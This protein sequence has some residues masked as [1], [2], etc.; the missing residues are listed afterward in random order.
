MNRLMKGINTT[1]TAKKCGH[2]YLYIALAD[3]KPN[4]ISYMGRTK[5]M[6]EAVCGG[7]NRVS[8]AIGQMEDL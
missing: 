5:T 4:P 1:V 3:L 7:F 8:V 2:S 6:A